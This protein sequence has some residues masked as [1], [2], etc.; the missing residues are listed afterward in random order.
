MI[1]FLYGKDGYRLQEKVKE[2]KAG[3]K[4][5]H[6]SGLNLQELDAKEQDF[7]LF[8]DGVQQTSMFIQKKLFF[9][10]NVFLA[11]DFKQKLEENIDRLAK[12]DDIVVIIE[13]DVGRKNDRFFKALKQKALTQEFK[14]LT[15]PELKQWARQ[16]LQRNKAQISERA[17]DL[18]LSYKDNN[19]WDLSNEID[20]LSCFSK[21]ITLEDIKLLIQPKIEAGIFETIDALAQRNKAQALALIQNHLDKGDSP[22]YLLTMITFQFRNLLTAALVREKGGAFQDLLQLKIAKPYPLH[23]AWQARPN[24]SLT[25]LK[26]I[27]SKIAE[28][29]LALKTGRLD[30][31]EG[32]RLLIAEI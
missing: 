9:L 5:K 6:G 19:L 8:W 10:E 30:P 20:K 23:K 13:R 15:T 29:D 31:E 32:I 26:K 1:L 25:Q 4:E 11:K 18:L 21:D 3:Y 17:L 2:I 27:Y 22:F 14:P 12:A 7:S 24:F 28:T 16:R